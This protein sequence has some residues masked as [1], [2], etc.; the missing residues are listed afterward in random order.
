MVFTRQFATMIDAGLPLVQC[1]DIQA[2]QQENKVFQEILRSMKSDVEQG[3][4]FADALEKH[5]KIFDDLYTNLVARG[6]DRRHP[7]HH[8]EPARDLSGE[9]GRPESAR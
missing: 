5:P 9:G 6:R 7:G 8:P 3:S 2:E 1:L 4:T